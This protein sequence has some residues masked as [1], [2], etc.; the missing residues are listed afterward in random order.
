MAQRATM[1]AL[2]RFS[3]TVVLLSLASFVTADFPFRAIL[4]ARDP[5]DSSTPVGG[6]AGT[7]S[8]NVA[9]IDPTTFTQDAY[10][11]AGTDTLLLDIINQME[12]RE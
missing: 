4:N 3:C 12:T 6:V 11:A 8:V 10:A 7:G 1:L 5:Q 9:C 2:P